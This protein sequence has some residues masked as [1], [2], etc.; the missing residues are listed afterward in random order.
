VVAAH[1][2]VTKDVPP[3][4]VVAGNPARV[5]RMRFKEDIIEHLLKSRWW[6][7]SIIDILMM[8]APRDIYSFIGAFD[9]NVERGTIRPLA[10]EY[11]GYD[12]ILRCSDQ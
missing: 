5:K 4:S 6:E 7:Y 9:K 8:T 1:A 10:L 11:L 12:T 2:L 3:Y